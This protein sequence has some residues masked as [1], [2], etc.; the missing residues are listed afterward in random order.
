MKTKKSMLLFIVALLTLVAC[1][2]TEP[3]DDSK[4]KKGQNV[5]MLFKGNS[6][7][8]D[9]YL[10]N[11]ESFVAYNLKKYPQDIKGQRYVTVRETEDNTIEL[12]DNLKFLLH[13]EYSLK[14]EGEKNI[15]QLTRTAKLL[16][17]N[18]NAPKKVIAENE[19]DLIQQT[20]TY[21]INTIT[22]ISLIAPEINNC[23]P[24]PLCYYDNFDIR[25]NEDNT[26]SNG[27]VIIAEWNGST[28][29][30]PAQNVSIANVDIV[31][32]TGS[33]IL[34]TD[35]FSDMPDEALVNLW[36]IRGNLITI[37]GEGEISLTELLNN[38]PGMIEELLA[39][40]PDLLLQLQPFMFGTGAVTTF[41]FFLIR[42]L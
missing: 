9:W 12:K 30:G 29:S 32:D 40:N 27:I 38:S 3:N 2:P 16:K 41:S 25:W 17:E 19:V 31:D 6:P 33:A 37:N 14:E 34:N 10:G 35:L 7:Y 42:E 8:L 1:N 24:I 15:L 13:D 20:Y 22:P 39:S 18:Q 26:N 23:N 4:N 36:L 11:Q 28:L 5:N 21:S